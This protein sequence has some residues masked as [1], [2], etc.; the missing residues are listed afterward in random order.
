MK[1]RIL[2]IG[3]SG[4]IGEALSNG[5]ND[6]EIGTFKGREIKTTKIKDIADILSGFDI[7]INLA[8][9]SIFTIWSKRTKQAIYD[10][11]IDTTSRIVSAINICKEPPKHII[12]ASAIG[13]YKPEVYVGEKDNNYADN[14]LSNVVKDWEYQLERIEEASI[15]KTFMRIGIVMSNKGGAYRT[16]KTLTKFNLGAY[17]NKG[18]QGFSFI[19]INDLVNAVDFIIKK[20]LTG[21]VNIVSPEVSNYRKL[22]QIMKKQHNALFIWRLP[23]FILKIIFGEASLLFLEGHRIRA[24]VLMENKFNYVAPDLNTCIKKLKED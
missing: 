18:K 13:I 21:P 9:R 3:A 12:N 10:S 1:K 17:F 23:G 14:F 11:R 20:G 8:G 16:L 19:L 7:I 6:Y 24:D 15:K 5:L 2:I 4:L 22:M